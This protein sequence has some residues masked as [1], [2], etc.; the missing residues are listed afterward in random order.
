MLDLNDLR[1]EM[2]RYMIDHPRGSLDS[3]ILHVLNLAYAQGLRDADNKQGDK[4]EQVI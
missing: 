4:N 2:A 1:H 3:A